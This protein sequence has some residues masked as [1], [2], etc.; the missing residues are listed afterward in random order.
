M[1]RNSSTPSCRQAVRPRRFTIASAADSC[2]RGCVGRVHNGRIGSTAAVWGRL[3]GRRLLAPSVTASAHGAIPELRADWPWHQPGDD[4]R[5]C[6][7]AATAAGKRATVRLGEICVI[8]DLNVPDVRFES[9]H[10][11]PEARTPDCTYFSAAAGRPEGKGIS[12]STRVAASLSRGSPHG[13]SGVAAGFG[14]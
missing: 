10:S 1:Q 9:G 13:R 3:G 7:I 14:P 2:R 6:P 11:L 8:P 5:P 12:S 4:S